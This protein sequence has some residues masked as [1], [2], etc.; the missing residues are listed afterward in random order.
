MPLASRSKNCRFPAPNRGRV[1]WRL[2]FA[3]LLTSLP[4]SPVT[5][6]MSGPLMRFWTL[7]RV[8]H[9]AATAT[10]HSGFPSY[11]QLAGFT[12]PG[13]ATPSGFLNL[14]TSCSAR[15]PSGLVSC[16]WRS[17]VFT[18]EGFP[19]LVAVPLLVTQRPAPLP[20]HRWLLDMQRFSPLHPPQFHPKSPL[21]RLR[22][23]D[24]GIL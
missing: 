19:S 16:R 21:R 7:Q 20:V 9:R 23:R 24:L 1:W 15:S 3:R 17:W 10:E 11:L 14:L 13:S 18:F 8:K 4:P 2:L 22:Y 5:P 12:S 6:K